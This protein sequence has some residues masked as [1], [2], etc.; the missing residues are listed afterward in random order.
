M[1]YTNILGVV[2]DNL[3][4]LLPV[5]TVFDYQ[6]AVR[7]T[8]GRIGPNLSPGWRF[9]LPLVQSIDVVDSTISSMDLQPQVICTKDDKQCAIRS[10]LEYR[11]VD[12]RTYFLTLQDN[13]AVPTVRIVARGFIAA[14][15][16]NYNYADLVR[17]KEEIEQV[18]TA[19]LQEKIQCWGLEAT[20]IHIAEYPKVRSLR[21]FGINDVIQEG[22]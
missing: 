5:R 7:W 9:F 22:P 14:E 21:L 15:L 18:L 19:K 11:I 13:D 12:A 17:V 10:G 16:S 20:K 2:M 8:F 1:E 6:Q 3:A 4:K